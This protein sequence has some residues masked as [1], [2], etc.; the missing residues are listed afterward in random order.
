MRGITRFTG[1]GRGIAALLLSLAVIA[2]PA[3]ASDYPSRPVRLI[4]P[5][6]TGGGTD[7]LARALAQR[8]SAVLDA[9]FVV[10][11]RPGAGGNLGAELAAKSA[12]DGH[13]LLVVSASYAVNAGFE[14]PRFDP[15]KDLAPVAQ[16]A[17][18]PF[19]LLGRTGLPVS[20]V[21]GLLDLARQKPGQL[22]YASSGVGSAPHLAGELLV[23]MTGT[24]M[25]HVPYK[26]G[27]PA[28]TDLLGGQVD[29]LFSTVVQG[30]PHLKAG[31]VKALAIAG[32]KRAPVLPDVPTIAESGVPGFD[33]TNWF[34]V[35]APARVPPEILEK[36][37]RAIVQQLGSPEL[38]E[39]MAAEGAEPRGGTAAEFGRLIEADIRKYSGVVETAGLR[40]Q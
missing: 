30:L 10:D 34:G 18:V 1:V 28:L 26:G 21:A 7:I 32:P 40:R 20:D 24:R 9:S 37:N 19:V 29:L 35:L 27:S 16:I 5:F 38:R 15:L 33:V 31:K 12:P 22:T 3:Q 23:G 36:L 17:S 11:N 13:T 39:Q 14:P 4:V 25:I 6:A 2:G 8:L